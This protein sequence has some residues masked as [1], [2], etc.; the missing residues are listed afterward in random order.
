MGFREERYKQSYSKEWN[1]TSASKPPAQ[2]GKESSPNR[3]NPQRSDEPR[4]CLKWLILNP[5]VPF[6]SASPSLTNLIERNNREIHPYSSPSSLDFLPLLSYPAQQQSRRPRSWCRLVDP[7]EQ[8]QSLRTLVERMEARS[9]NRLMMSTRPRGGTRVL[10]RRRR[11][12]RRSRRV[13][14]LSRYIF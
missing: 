7:V 10:R 8:E 3:P 13:L 1:P 14:S 2:T 6:R 4:R 11:R 9:W 5:F 12:G